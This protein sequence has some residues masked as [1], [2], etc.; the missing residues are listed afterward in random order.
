M[1]ISQITIGPA[2]LNCEK[3]TASHCPYFFRAYLKNSG[4]VTSKSCFDWSPMTWLSPS[5]GAKSVP[6]RFKVSPSP[7]QLQRHPARSNCFS[8]MTSNR[9][10]ANG[11]T[12]RHSSPWTFRWPVTSKGAVLISISNARWVQVAEASDLSGIGVA[13]IGVVG[14]NKK[15]IGGRTFI[16]FFRSWRDRFW[17][18]A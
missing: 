11:Q 14:I 9:H 8:F 13:F 2:N 12:I 18:L 1:Q 4:S 16:I 17:A 7:L 5:V 3:T 10:H 6:R 15:I